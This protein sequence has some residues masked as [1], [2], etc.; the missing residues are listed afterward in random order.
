MSAFY[1]VS[2]SGCVTEHARIKSCQK[3]R[4]IRNRKAIIFPVSFTH[5]P[6]VFHLFSVVMSVLHNVRNCVINIVRRWIT[7]LDCIFPRSTMAWL[8]GKYY[9][10]DFVDI[11]QAIRS[12]YT[13]AYISLLKNLSE[14]HLLWLWCC[15]PFRTF[16][17]L[18]SMS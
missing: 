2:V 6:T 15:C 8:L 14:K 16:V 17:Y 5:F 12:V 9:Q 13:Y 3:G 1:R 4:H 11:L 7:Q 10:F 18:I